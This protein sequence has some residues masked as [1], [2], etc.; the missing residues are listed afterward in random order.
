MLSKLKSM[1]VSQFKDFIERILAFIVFSLIAVVAVLVIGTLLG[2][3]FS[4]TEIGLLQSIGYFLL[5][6]LASSGIGLILGTLIKGEQ[7]AVYIGIGVV[8]ITS[9]TSGISTTYS[10]L[11]P[12]LQFFSRIYPISSSNSSLIYIL[13][14]EKMAGYNPLELSQITLTAFSSIILFA[15]GLAI[16]AR[17]CWRKD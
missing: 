4:A 5:P 16:Y 14:G 15:V 11:I 13:I 6:I 12:V 17:Y 9:F 7:G 10:Q 1:P 3:K 8:L 2:A